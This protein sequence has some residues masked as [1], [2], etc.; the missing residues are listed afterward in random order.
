MKLSKYLLSIRLQSG[1]I[2][3]PD[4]ISN[5]NIPLSESYYRDIE[6]GRKKIGLDKVLDVFSTLPN[7]NFNKLALFC[8]QD[9]LP[10][11]ISEKILKIE[12][13]IDVEYANIEDFSRFTNHK[14]QITNNIYLDALDAQNLFFTPSDDD[15]DFIF[16]NLNLLPLIHFCYL[17]NSVSISEVNEICFKNKI[18]HSE[19][20]VKELLCRFLNTSDGN[21]FF[22]KNKIFKLGN[23]EKSKQLKSI[24]NCLEVEKSL[25][26]NGSLIRQFGIV[27]IQYNQLMSIKESLL[28]LMAEVNMAEIDLTDDTDSKVYFL[29]IF[30]SER[31]EYKI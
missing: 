7:V 29:S 17:K 4:Y 16:D 15:V 2:N 30:F 24:F 23:N 5:Y 13:D 19:N 10:K 12:S 22:R 18:N 20:N 28:K 26:T 21:I 3:I 11:K 14:S 1:I 8:I 31:D 9:T 25:S 6:S 27:S